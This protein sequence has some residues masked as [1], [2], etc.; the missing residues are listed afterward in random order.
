MSPKYQLLVQ[1]CNNAFEAFNIILTHVRGNQFEYVTNLLHQITHIKFRSL[2]DFIDQFSTLSTS[3]M[4][5]DNKINDYF[6][7]LLFRSSIPTKGQLF[8][9]M[10]DQCAHEQLT[11]HE[12]ISHFTNFIPAKTLTAKTKPKQRPNNK[13][14]TNR[15]I[16]QANQVT[17]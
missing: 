5:A 7:R 1:R 10:L 17:V 6:M 8:A 12:Y 2:Q 15:A 13:N 9:K 16:K 4:Q 3:I 11:L 14:S